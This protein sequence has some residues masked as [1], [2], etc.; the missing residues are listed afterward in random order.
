VTAANRTLPRSSAVAFVCSDALAAGSVITKIRSR[1][2][3]EEGAA[4]S[5]GCVVSAEPV[6]EDSS[7]L[8][9]ELS[10]ADSFF[11]C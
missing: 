11:V 9:V 1:S 2:G 6:F 5:S 10:G 3:S 4:D 8:G 7:V